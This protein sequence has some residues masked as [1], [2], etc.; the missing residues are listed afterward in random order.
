MVDQEL[1]LLSSK[2]DAG[3]KAA[4]A[5]AIERHRKLGQ[6]ISIIQDGKIVTLTA[7][8]I[9]VIQTQQNSDK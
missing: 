3:V 2:I 5:A 7:D 1:E 6:S 4:I 8:K 9:P